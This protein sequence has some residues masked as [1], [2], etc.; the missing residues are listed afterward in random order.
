MVWAR[1]KRPKVM[2][3][4]EGIVKGEEGS[5]MCHTRPSQAIRRTMWLGRRHRSKA[6]APLVGL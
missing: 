5:I 3:E 2:G 6:V 4:E 1:V